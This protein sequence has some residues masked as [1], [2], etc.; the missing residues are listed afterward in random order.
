MPPSHATKVATVAVRKVSFSV[1]LVIDS[2]FA[3]H[4]GA[5]NSAQLANKNKNVGRK[6]PT[7]KFLPKSDESFPNIVSG[8]ISGREAAASSWTIRAGRSRLYA[9]LPTVFASLQKASCVR[10]QKGRVSAPCFLWLSPSFAALP[11]VLALLR[12]AFCVRRQKGRVSAPCS[13]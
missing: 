6:N 12:K 2:V 8:Q 3:N 4:V 7:A 1:Q 5:P 13:L 11:T 10:R 9:A